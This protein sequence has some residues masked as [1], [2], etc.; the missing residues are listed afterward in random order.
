MLD[1]VTG[2]RVFVR[3]VAAGSLSA[4]AR[5]LDMSAA[6]AT[7]HID[8]LES[9]LGVKLLHRTTR[10]LSLT[11]AGS[12]YLEACQRILPEIDEAEAVAASQRIERAACCASTRRCRSAV[13]SSRPCC[14]HSVAAIPPCASSWD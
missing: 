2:M 1:R 10:R 4:A 8:A 9:R 12:D 6:M 11:E 5:Q 13:V 14:R 7:K 3:A